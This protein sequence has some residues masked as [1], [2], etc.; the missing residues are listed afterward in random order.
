MEQD[1]SRKKNSQR[2]SDFLRLLI[3]IFSSILLL[4][5]NSCDLQKKEPLPIIGT[6]N[7]PYTFTDQDGE[8]I[9]HTL[10][11]GHIYVADFFFT[12][13]PTICPL[14]KTQMSR[15]Y[16]AFKDN[17][18]VLLLSYSIDPEH[19]TVEVLHDYAQRLQISSA[20]WHMVTG[21]K[22][23]IYKTAKLYMLAALEDEQAPGGY[24][25]SGSFCLVDQDGNIRGY[26]RGT[27]EE[28]VD[29]LIDDI[30]RLLNEKN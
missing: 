3:C 8:T 17:S 4:T 21:D 7:V 13:C 10:F 30:K 23:Q 1:T 14:M 20:K 29:R 5:L 24:I 19:D 6:I 11:K 26:Y 2:T 12:S 15:V 9:S 18:T 22:E 27:E 25:H 28:A 16:D